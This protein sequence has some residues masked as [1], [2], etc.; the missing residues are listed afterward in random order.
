MAVC[1]TV[2]FKDF[3]P[4]FRL[5]A[6]FY[7]SPAAALRKTLSKYGLP[8]SRWF[9]AVIHPPEFM[10]KYVDEPGHTF[11]RAQNVRPG[12]IENRE[13]VY[14]DD[15][16][17][18]SYPDAIVR[19]NELLLVRTGA[20][21][22]DC[23]RVTKEW[24][25]A[26]V[27]SHTLRLIPADDAPICGLEFFFSAPSGRQLLL[28]LRSG[29][30]HGQINAENLRRLSLP[31]LSS[32]EYE[33]RE[34]ATNIELNRRR[35]REGLVNAELELMRLLGIGNSKTSINLTYQ[36][37]FKDLQTANRW[38]AE[39]FMPCKQHVID[40]LL[41]KRGQPLSSYYASVREMF[42]PLQAVSSKQVRNFD[43]TDALDPVLDDGIAAIPAEK[44]G[45]IKK[46]ISAGDVVVSRLRSYLREIALVRTSAKIPAVGSSEFIVLRRKKKTA[47]TPETLLVYLR[48]LPVQTILN[49]SQ[50]GS[51]HPRFNEDVLLG[52]PIPD[53]LI[54]GAQNIDGAVASALSAQA[55]AASLFE[56]GKANVERIVRGIG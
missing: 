55:E 29:G 3:G 46:K 35:M 41:A 4:A 54:T 11:L 16:I 28:G 5:D 56:Q 21:H 12:I 47:P 48:S 25:G 44:V 30:T 19:T 1:T 39:Y 18:H 38:G 6:E 33:M 49:W 10:R 32:A 20:N 50:D 52:V 45:S 2:N 7:T 13:P 23:A 43:L 36:R 53:D 14:V 22:G 42:D 26:M 17:Y 27:S 40:A 15:A 31:D 24:A 9:N 8:F 34:L 51:Q 37:D